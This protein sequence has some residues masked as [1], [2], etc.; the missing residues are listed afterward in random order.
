[1]GFFDAIFGGAGGSV[2]NGAKARELV[3][4]GA[5]LVDVRSPAEYAGGHVDG[6]KNLPVDTLP[7]AASGLA[8]DKVVVVYCRSGARSARAAG[9]LKQSGFSEVYDLGSIANW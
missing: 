5:Q 3:A 9:L 8:R 4:A 6:A 2:I 7:A 1:M